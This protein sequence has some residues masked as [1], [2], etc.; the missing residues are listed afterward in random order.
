MHWHGLRR[1]PA[2]AALREQSIC[3]V[4]RL[5]PARRGGGGCSRRPRIPPSSPAPSSGTWR[6]EVGH[7]LFAAPRLRR[8]GSPAAGDRG[9]KQGLCRAPSPLRG[10]AH[11]RWEKKGKLARGCLGSLPSLPQARLW[12]YQACRKESRTGRRGDSAPFSQP[13]RIPGLPVGAA[14][15]QPSAMGRKITPGRET[16][17]P[18]TSER[19]I[20]SFP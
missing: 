16:P 18:Q 19:R 12:Q 9:T 4:R 3:R 5:M 15:S 1:H 14:P 8:R 6:S 17:P 13:E 20:Y 10:N 2:L 11:G 7:R